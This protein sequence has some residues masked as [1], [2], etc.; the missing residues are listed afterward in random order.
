MIAR[1]ILLGALTALVCG[2]G[3]GDVGQVSGTVTLSGQPLAEGTVVFENTPAGI[4]VNAEIGPDGSYTV[5][6]YELSGL[7][8]GTYQVAIKPASI[9]DGETPLVSDPSEEIA[10]PAS[11]I[12]EKYRSVETSELTV[13]VVSGGNPPF[14]FDLQP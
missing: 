10:T 8:P 14:D 2:C 6:T 1:M 4:S 12:P 9:G 5:K 7:P 13:T 3:G 11:V